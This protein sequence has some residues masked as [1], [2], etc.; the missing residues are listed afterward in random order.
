MGQSFGD[1][2]TDYEKYVRTTDLYKLIREEDACVNPDEQLFQVTHMAMELWLSTVIQ[3][4]NQVTAWLADDERL[5][6]ATRFLNRAADIVSMLLD[7]LRHL[8]KMSPWNYH[9]IRMGLG[10]GSGQQSPTY[11]FLQEMPS[12]LWEA[13]SAV[14]ER[15]KISI[16]DIQRTPHESTLLWE[17]TNAMMLFDENFLRWRYGHYQLVKRIIGSKVLSL[18]GVPASALERTTH[19][20]LFPELWEAINTTTANWNNEHGT[21]GDSGAYR[22]PDQE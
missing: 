22:V 12:Q 21:P 14:L 4:L 17:L 3:H 20:E 2:S 15:H 16:A 5:R 9:A 11:N 19:Q 1:G 10:K 18:K 7:S 8:E 6:D 13:Y